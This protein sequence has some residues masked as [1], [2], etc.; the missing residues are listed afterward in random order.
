MSLVRNQPS[1]SDAAFASGRRQYPCAMIVGPFS[2][3]SP[4]V[5]GGTS[6]PC[7]STMRSS[8]VGTARPTEPGCA[9]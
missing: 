6:L 5:P 3:T 2:H 7:S 8:T 9:K 1:V 4:F